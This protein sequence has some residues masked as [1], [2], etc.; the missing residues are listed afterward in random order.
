V[1]HWRRLKQPAQTLVEVA[2]PVGRRRR[3]HHKRAGRD[4]RAGDVAQRLGRAVIGQMLK[5]AQVHAQRADPGSVL[6]R[7]ADPD[8]KRPGA[9]V[10]ATAAPA[11]G[12]MLADAQ[13]HALGHIEDL[14]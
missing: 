14:A 3:P 1:R 6:R 12:D 9:D 4:A 5:D 13:Q 11:H 8:R 10:P 7:R 2:Q